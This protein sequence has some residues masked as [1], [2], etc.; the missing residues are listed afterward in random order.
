M[1][2]TWMM[3]FAT[4][5][6][7]PTP[8]FS[9]PTWEFSIA[10]PQANLTMASLRQHCT[11][12]PHTSQRLYPNAQCRH[13]GALH[14]RRTSR[15]LSC[16]SYSRSFLYFRCRH[17]VEL[18][19]GCRC[20]SFLFTIPTNVRLA[21]STPTFLFLSYFNMTYNFLSFYLMCAPV[22]LCAPVCSGHCPVKV[23][24]KFCDFAI[25]RVPHRE[26]TCWPSSRESQQV[27][28]DLKPFTTIHNAIAI[29]ARNIP[30]TCGWKPHDSEVLSV[31]LIF[32]TELT[33]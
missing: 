7:H 4:S 29:A 15:L 10:S 22:R 21:T 13:S 24:R 31:S 33:L 17:V 11:A 2:S 16:F 3:A 25:S 26:S 30:A 1:T 20:R 6:R 18:L 23:S 19:H 5:S 12:T 27:S 14:K 28:S 9:H 32:W 8:A